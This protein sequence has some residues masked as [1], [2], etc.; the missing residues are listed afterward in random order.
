MQTLRLEDRPVPVQTSEIWRN[1][2]HSTALSDGDRQLSYEGLDRR[3]DRFAGY[4]AQ[5]GVAAGAT[6]AICMER[7]FDWIVAALGLMRAG[8]A[9]VPLDAAWPDSRLSFALG[10]STASV[11]VANSGLLDRLGTKIHGVDLQRDADLIAAAPEFV[12]APVD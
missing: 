3:A 6:V 7:S 8:A 12:P 4:L 11:L 5:L 9:Y 1:H 2:P 10:D